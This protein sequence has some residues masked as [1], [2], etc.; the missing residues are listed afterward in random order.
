MIN[1]CNLEDIDK[2]SELGILINKKFNKVNDIK[3]IIEKE[4]IIGII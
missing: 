3:D 2:I 1:K 4:N